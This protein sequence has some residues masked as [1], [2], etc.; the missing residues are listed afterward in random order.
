ML[1]SGIAAK[2]NG[3]DSLQAAGSPRFFHSRSVGST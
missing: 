1:L 3:A 2:A